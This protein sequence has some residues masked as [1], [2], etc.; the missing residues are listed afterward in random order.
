[1]SNPS[2]NKR[3]PHITEAEIEE[4]FGGERC[5]VLA[6]QGYVYFIQLSNGLTKVGFSSRS[7]ECRLSAHRNTAIF[8]GAVPVLSFVSSLINGPT[9]LERLLIKRCMTS[10]QQA[11]GRE[12]YRGVDASYLEEIINNWP[13]HEQHE[14][15]IKGAKIA[16]RNSARLSAFFERASP[17]AKISSH[18]HEWMSCSPHAK[19]LFDIVVGEIPANVPGCDAEEALGGISKLELFIWT[20]LYNSPHAEWP[21]L[22][23]MAEDA[24]REFAIHA[25]TVARENWIREMSADNTSPA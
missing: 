25:A 15:C 22:F 8:M 10:Y 20:M 1:M 4:I 16:E 24:P 7:P 17:A 9:G 13:F 14:L 3:N 6:R 19:V 5:S 21:E 11:H 12:W 23:R 2:I 18:G